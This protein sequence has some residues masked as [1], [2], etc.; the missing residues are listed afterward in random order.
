MYQGNG[1]ATKLVHSILFNLEIKYENAYEYISN[2][3]IAS[4]RVAKKNG[5]KKIN[6]AIMKGFFR[7]V[8]VSIDGEYGIW[9]F[10]ND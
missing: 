10:K 7:E 2:S 5:F 4:I 9:C 1:F 8:V 3:N 6:N